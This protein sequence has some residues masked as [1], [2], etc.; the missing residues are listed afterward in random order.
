MGLL[1]MSQRYKKTPSELLSIDDAYTAYCLN[2][3]C[4]YI[5]GMLDKGEEPIF[6]RS[7][8]SFSELYAPYVN[9]G[10]NH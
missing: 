8:H 2:E 10:D 3:A 5:M 9:G 1:A 4:A 7:C 6:S